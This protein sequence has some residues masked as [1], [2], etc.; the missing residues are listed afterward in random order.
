MTRLVTVNVTQ[1]DIELGVRNSS[2]HCPVA[3]ALHRHRP[4]RY[5]T[6]NGFEAY[7]PW[8]GTTPLPLNVQQ[9]VAAFDDGDPVAPLQ[10]TVEVPS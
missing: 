10:F 2:T 5:A 9:F 4:F 1:R 7:N 3:R 8:H 6:V